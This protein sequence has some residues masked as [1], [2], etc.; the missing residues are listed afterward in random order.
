VER[1]KQTGTPIC[2]PQ[3]LADV[4]ARRLAAMEQV[5]LTEG[6]DF[7]Q[8][9]LWNFRMGG[10]FVGISDRRFGL[11]METDLTNVTF[12]LDRRMT[13]DM[14]LG[15][16]LTFENSQTDG[17]SNTL[18][19]ETKGFAIGPYAAI[20][21]SP[22]WAI[23]TSVTYG[24][25]DSDV[26]LSILNGDYSAQRFTGDINLHGQ[27]KIDEYFIRPK[28]SV[29]F[30]HIANDEYSLDGTVLNAPVNVEYPEE[31]FNYGVMTASTEVSR[32]FQFTNG[33]PLLAFAEVGAQYEFER[34]N[35]GEIMTGDLSMATPSPWS[36]SLRSG[37]RMLLS[38]SLQLEASGGYLSFGQSGLDIWEGKLE[39]SMSF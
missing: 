26:E 12:G 3:F 7:G 17:F 13:D 14:V 15:V 30:S 23:D 38:N 35:G 22:H 4:E 33:T 16:A 25:Y 19:V 8:A 21:L 10:S 20:R 6:R 11:D 29:S 39:L 37:V 9:S 28:V 31:S 2:T 27:Y 1:S 5:P 18:G 24:S 32:M 36:F 34:P